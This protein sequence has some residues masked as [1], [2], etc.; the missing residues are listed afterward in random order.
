MTKLS[1]AEE[2]SGSFDFKYS[3]FDDHQE[4]VVNKFLVHLALSTDD[5]QQV[6]IIVSSAKFNGSSYPSNSRNRLNTF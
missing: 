6:K 4:K 2:E 5:P 1:L 3:F